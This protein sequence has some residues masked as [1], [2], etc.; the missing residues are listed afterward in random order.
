MQS[1]IDRHARV[2]HDLAV[3]QALYGHP[4]G[5]VPPKVLASDFV[6]AIPTHYASEHRIAATRSLRL[7]TLALNLLQPQTSIEKLKII[8]HNAFEGM[9]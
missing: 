8:V 3:L 7:V 9:N 5:E 2:Q 1:L 6:V 4:E